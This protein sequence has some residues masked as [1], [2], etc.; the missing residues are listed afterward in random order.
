MTKPVTD[1]LAGL[2]IP[3]GLPLL[4]IND[5]VPNI[6]EPNLPLYSSISS[7]KFGLEFG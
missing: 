4:I 3:E 5:P 1:T 6:I 7:I 2:R